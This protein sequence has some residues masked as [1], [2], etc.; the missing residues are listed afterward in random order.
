MRRASLYLSLVLLL[1]LI[2]ISFSF[3]VQLHPPAF[4]SSFL[5]HASAMQQPWKQPQARASSASAPINPPRKN[6]SP[7]LF[8]SRYP[9]ASDVSLEEGELGLVSEGSECTDTSP[10]SSRCN[11]PTADSHSSFLPT[12]TAATG[13][14]QSAEPLPKVLFIIGPTGVGKSKLSLDLCLALKA[15]GVSAEIISAD[16]MQ[17]YRGCDIATAKATPA[18]RKRVP[19]HLLDVCSP[20]EA[21]T[22]ADYLR[23]AKTIIT[24]LTKAG[25]L[26]V[27][28]G[29][30][31]L[32]IQLLLWESAVEQD[33]AGG[34]TGN[35]TFS[36]SSVAAL[37]HMTNEELMNIL[38]KL[39]SK[40]A[41]QL[42]LRDRRRIIRSIE[43]AKSPSANI[44]LFLSSALTSCACRSGEK[45]LRNE[46][47]AHFGVPHS[48]L[49]EKHRR[50]DIR[51]DACIL[52]LDVRDRLALERRLRARL[53]EMCANG[54]L[55]EVRWLAGEL[56]PRESPADGYEEGVA[57]LDE[58]LSAS[59]EGEEDGSMRPRTGK[60]GRKGVLQGI[61][62]KELLPLVQSEGNAGANSQKGG[63][64]TLDACIDTVVLRSLQYARQQRKWIKNKFLIRQRNVPLYFLE[65]T[66]EAVAAWKDQVL[67]PALQ[68]VEDFLGGRSF[69]EE[70]EWAAA[71]RLP[72]AVKLRAET[73]GDG[74]ISNCNDCM[75]CDRCRRTFYGPLAYQQHLLSPKR[76]KRRGEKFALNVE[77][78]DDKPVI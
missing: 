50:R 27:V 63:P 25:K 59:S 55:D 20:N 5:R 44:Q 16:S 10:R 3:S 51:Y 43:E 69:S 23:S 34:E 64:P 47:T 66:D 2:L 72:E 48:E 42:H 36:S 19:H 45:C 78:V 12:L 4:F 37:H 7:P 33:E 54:L 73:G 35:K 70:H 53:S 14:R 41:Q 46:I 6:S 40:R 13:P 26:P 9:N 28:V 29:G 68:I 60:P 58:G 21:F 31:Q 61:G 74:N 15:R 77:V 39:D 56:K 11:S 67:G 52:W 76:C 38:R 30:T 32:Y 8:S 17:V 49:I 18:E 1:Q 65:T 71:M 22:A 75:I 62:Y 24:D 57:P